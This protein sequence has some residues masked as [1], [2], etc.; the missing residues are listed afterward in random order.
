MKLLET[1]TLA[2]TSAVPWQDWPSCNH[3][4]FFDP[5]T[6]GGADQSWLAN[7]SS[8]SDNQ[9]PTESDEDWEES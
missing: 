6:E 2:A 1:T 3:S 4:G 7:S 9:S 5:R 8:S